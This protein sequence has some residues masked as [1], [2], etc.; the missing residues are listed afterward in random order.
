MSANSAFFTDETLRFLRGLKKNNDRQWFGASKSIYESAVKA[1]LLAFASSLSESIATVAPEYA[2]APEKAVQRIYR[3]IR[4][5]PNKTPYRTELGIL[6]THRGLGKDAGSGVYISLSPEKVLVAGGLYQQDSR[7]LNTI[8]QHLLGNLDEFGKLLKGKALRSTF[9]PLHGESLKRPPRGIPA[10]HPSIDLLKQTQWL[11]AANLPPESMTE[12]GFEK[13][14]FGHVRTLL[15]F[16]RFFEA[17]L[18]V[19]AKPILL[20]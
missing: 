4:F 3:D 12:P 13:A 17:P 7:G 6:F 11:L 8:R 15:P 18:L 2:T 9:G 20:D 14:V 19:K 10:D 16:V 5:S 1:P